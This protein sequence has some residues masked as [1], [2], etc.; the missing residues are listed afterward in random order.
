MLTRESRRLQEVE[1]EQ[2]NNEI[3]QYVTNFP[4][5]FSLPKRKELMEQVRELLSNA[6]SEKYG[7]LDEG[8]GWTCLENNDQ[9]ILG[10]LKSSSLRNCTVNNYMT[11]NFSCIENRNRS[12]RVDDGRDI[13]DRAKCHY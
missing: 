6:K 9:T 12:G 13:F 10:K 4:K 8:N 7:K 5:I 3:D 2:I 1:E 11:K